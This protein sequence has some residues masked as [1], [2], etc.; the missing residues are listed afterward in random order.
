MYTYQDLLDVGDV[1]ND[2]M[3]FVKL[4][5]KAHKDTASIGLETVSQIVLEQIV[6]LRLYTESWCR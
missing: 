4:A 1:E 6:Y 3:E 2:R 5:V